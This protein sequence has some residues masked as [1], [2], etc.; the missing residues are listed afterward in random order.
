MN[1]ENIPFLTLTILHLSQALEIKKASDQEV[2]DTCHEEAGAESD[3][4]KKAAKAK[5]KILRET[6]SESEG[7]QFSNMLHAYR[8]CLYLSN[9]VSTTCHFIFCFTLV[10][11]AAASQ[12]L[13]KAQNKEVE[14]L[15]YMIKE[16]SEERESEKADIETPDQIQAVLSLDRVQLIKADDKSETQRKAAEDIKAYQDD[17][18]LTLNKKLEGEEAVLVACEED[19]AVLEKQLEALATDGTLSPEQTDNGTGTGETVQDISNATNQPQREALQALLD[20]READLLATK[21]AREE[22]QGQIRRYVWGFYRSLYLK[23][24]AS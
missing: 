17:A 21:Q 24:L 8:F 13:R 15:N 22:T 20:E 2:A 14:M 10:I 5:L 4:D 7:E 3:S 16:A 6:A 1:L 19:I 11:L 9:V 12:K 18:M 23:T